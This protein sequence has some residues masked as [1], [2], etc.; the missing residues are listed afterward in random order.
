L[1]LQR[2]PGDRRGQMAARVLVVLFL[3]INLAEQRLQLF[4]DVIGQFAKAAQFRQR[5]ESFSK[6]P[7]QEQMA[8]GGQQNVNE[9]ERPAHVAASVRQIAG[10]IRASQ[11]EDYNPS[12][13]CRKSRMTW[14]LVHEEEDVSSGI[15]G[16]GPSQ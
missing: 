3:Q 14:K 11:L 16:T 12:D 2:P 8:A 7:H 13:L 15:A 5:I 6:T 10:R 4:M 1:R 9:I